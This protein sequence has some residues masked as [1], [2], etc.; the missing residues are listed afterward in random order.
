MQY[1]VTCRS[2]RRN[3]AGHISGSTTNPV[4]G[5]QSSVV[6]CQLSVVSCRNLEIST[7]PI[8]AIRFI[9][10]SQSSHFFEKDVIHESN[11]V[12]KGFA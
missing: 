2:K 5:G 8:R 10:G 3:S 6:S 1:S 7:L 11:A 9:R 4:R 12:F